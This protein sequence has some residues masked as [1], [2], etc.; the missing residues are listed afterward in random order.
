M[1]KIAVI[2]D[3]TSV[4]DESILEVNDNLYSV[5][6]HIVF[7][8]KS[9]R[10]GIDIS[11]DE[12]FE[13]MSDSSILPTTSQPSVGEVIELL[14]SIKEKYDHIIYI[15]ISS[16]ISGTYQTGMLAKNEVSDN[17][18]VF[19]SL[20]TSVVQKE[21]VLETLNMINENKLIE[22]ITENLERIRTNSNVLL[23][24]DDLKHLN[25]TGRISLTTASIGNMLKLKPILS[26]VDGKIVVKKKI[27]TLRKAHS[28]IVEFVT[29]IGI[30]SDSKLMIAHA[31]GFEA[32][33]RLKDELLGIYP[34]HEITIS[35]LSPVIS[36][37]TGPNTVGIAWIK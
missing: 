31:K 29:E 36:L 25:R 20:I 18:T 26:F 21:M 2:T 15:T 12:F 37:H 22:K 1:K 17:I 11:S 16:G 9:Y 6:L 13:K 27:R 7:N 4:I 24:V 5:P 19:D 14:E 28:H 30:A 34:H 33:S 23:V 35:E 8:E 32:A 3:S 10:D